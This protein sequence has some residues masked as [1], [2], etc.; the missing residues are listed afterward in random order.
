MVEAVG[1]AASGPKDKLKPHRFTCDDPRASDVRIDIL[2]CGVCHSD[3][4][5]VKNEWG[6]TVY[7][8]MPGHEIVGRV[9]AIGDSVTRH[10]VG[11]IV[12][13]GCMI[14]S[15]RACEACRAG[16][17]NYCIGPNS[18]LATYNGPMVPAAKAPDGRN[19]YERDN[20][21]GGYSTTIV[22]KEDFV[23]RI[24]QG[25][26]PEQAAPIL[27]A[28]VT[29]YSPMKHWGVKAG[30]QVGILGYGGLGNMAGKI[31]KAL[32]AHVTVF[33][34]HPEKQGP[35]ETAG[36]DR[37]IV[38][39]DDKTL[40]SLAGTFDFILS[41]VP[42]KHDI[43]PYIPLLKRDKTLV[44]VGALEPM[45][46]VNHMP[47][48]FKRRSIA[49]SL[50]GSIAETQEILDFCAQHKIAPDIQLIPI[51]QINEAYDHVEQGDVRFRYVL[52]IKKRAATTTQKA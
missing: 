34:T 2:Y 28:G 8:C 19:T 22:V 21:F 44:A 41:T 33:T 16:E 27:C 24:P 20:T 51:E 15:C 13:V 32:G 50:I 6:N 43:N 14:D 40:Q 36:V 38:E 39:T 46:S 1:Y 11:D 9:A 12:G 37:V 23:L 5:Q 31:A 42:E 3:I 35:A 17:E 52:D 29:T 49:G 30:D 48:A 4:H 25:L 7:P 47:V 18:W 45:A 26:S 10:K